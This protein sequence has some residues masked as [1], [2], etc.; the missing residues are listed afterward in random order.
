MCAEKEP[1]TLKESFHVPGSHKGP[2]GFHRAVLVLEADDSLTLSLHGGDELE[3][4]D[5]DSTKEDTK[6]ITQFKPFLSLQNRQ[7][8]TATQAKMQVTQSA[9][10]RE[11]KGGLS[12]KEEPRSAAGVE[13]ETRCPSQSSTN[14]SSD[15]C[16]QNSH[17]L[18][19]RQPKTS[20]SD[21]T[22]VYEPEHPINDTLTQVASSNS[23]SLPK[24]LTTAAPSRDITYSDTPAPINPDHHFI[25]ADTRH[26]SIQDEHIR[27]QRARGHAAAPRYGRQKSRRSRRRAGKPRCSIM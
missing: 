24:K 13:K 22:N 21:P 5:T 14:P 2:H 23:L 9:S 25:I 1:P 11:V 6:D 16:V 4:Q 18:P 26:R 20:V 8:K 19:F 17:G 15:S 3:S 10:L 27:H 12:V 7:K